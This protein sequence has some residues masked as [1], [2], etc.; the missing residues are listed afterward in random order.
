MVKNNQFGTSSNFYK[1]RKRPHSVSLHCVLSAPSFSSARGRLATQRI[2]N[3]FV[4]FHYTPFF[5]TAFPRLL[6]AV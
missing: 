4:P 2:A 5:A 1:G 6:K 3:H